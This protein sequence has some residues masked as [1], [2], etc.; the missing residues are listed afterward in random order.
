MIN[1][2]FRYLNYGGIGYSIGHE[3]THGFDS[4]GTLFIKW[5]IVENHRFTRGSHKLS[6]K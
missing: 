2:L 4:K 5:K 1:F 6:C 3:I